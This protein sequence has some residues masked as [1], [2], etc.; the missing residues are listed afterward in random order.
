MMTLKNRAS[1]SASE[2]RYH[3]ISA[4]AFRDTV[5]IIAVTTVL[6]RTEVDNRSAGREK[7][8]IRRLTEALQ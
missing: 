8:A 7:V 2:T 1:I 5:G 4:S 6:D 3:Q